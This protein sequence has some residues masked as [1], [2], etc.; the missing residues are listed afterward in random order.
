MKKGIKNAFLGFL[1]GVCM[2]VPGVSGGSIAVMLGIY[3]DLLYAVSDLFKN[4]KQNMFF[5]LSV[6][7]GGILG[8]AVMAK[9]VDLLIEIAYFQTIYFF[10]GVIIGGLFPLYQT[11]FSEKEKLNIP[12][13]VLGVLAVVALGLLPSNLFTVGSGSIWLRF[14]LFVFAGLLLS[15]AFILP[16]VSFSLM[17]VILGLYDQ[18]IQAIDNFNFRF[19]CPIGLCTLFGT[20]VLSKV[21]SHFLRSAPNYC[22]SMI[23][24][25]VLASLFELFPGIPTHDVVWCL[26]L[27]LTGILFPNLVF[28]ITEKNQL[29]VSSQCD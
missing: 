1:I 10:I 12:M 28:I 14:L 8:F 22:H 13:T 27:L 9:G 23:V 2:L 11:S 6:A 20:I 4:F 19:L 24:G 21:L 17:L 29:S 5:L 3:D 18:F 15:A 16:G 26:L 7:V 25:F